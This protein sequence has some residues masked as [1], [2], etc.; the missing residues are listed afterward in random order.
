MDGY[1]VMT[2]TPDADHV[3]LY[4][5]MPDGVDAVTVTLADGTTSELPV[6]DNAYLAQ[7]DQATS[8]I[9]WHDADG[10]EHAL[11]AGSNG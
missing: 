1:F 2:L 9:S 11:N 10:V 8:T 3:E 7:F 6:V 4:G 5:L